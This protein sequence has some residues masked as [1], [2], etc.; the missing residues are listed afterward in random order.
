MTARRCLWPSCRNPAS[1]LVYCY[2]HYPALGEELQ[3]RL[4]A[5]QGTTDWVAR[6]T[7]C[8]DHAKATIGWVKHNVTGGSHADSDSPR[9]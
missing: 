5:A 8:Q 9:R 7:A 3:A 6:L 4:R 1:Q 2:Q